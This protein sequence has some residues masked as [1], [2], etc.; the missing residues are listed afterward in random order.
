[1]GS[2]RVSGMRIFVDGEPAE[3][4]ELF[5]TNSN[6][7]ARAFGAVMRIG[8][9]KHAGNW[10]GEVEDLRFY[11]TRTL[12]EAEARVLAVSESVEKIAGVAAEERTDEQQEKLRLHFLENAAPKPIQQ[13]LGQIRKAEAKRLAFADGLP[14][15]MVMQEM[16]PPRSTM[17]RKR[18]E[19]H[20]HGE[21]VEPGVPA[22]FPE[23]PDGAARNRLGFARWLVSGEHP[24][25]AR[26]A[27]NRYWQLLFGQGLVKT[28][29]DFG[30]QGDLPTH[31]EL[32]DFLAI[33]FVES[34]WDVR[35][36]LKTIVLSKTYRQSSRMTPELIVAAP[37]NRLYARA[38]RLRM[39][40]NTLRDQAL[41]VSGLLV[42]KPG[43]AS[44][45]PYQPAKLW[46]EASNVSYA[47]GKG[48]DLY[49]RS[50]YTYWKRT[51]APPSMAVLDTADR[52]W[53][54]VKPRQTNTPLQALTLLN[55]TGF[56]ESA[57]KFGERILAEGGDS[58]VERIEFGFRAVLARRPTELEQQLLAE[59]YAGYRADFTADPQSAKQTL[60]TGS[61]KPAAGDPVE[62]AAAAALANVLLNL[63]E[64]TTRE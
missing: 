15:T 6:R 41:F 35:H 48:D 4:R 58:D 61:S 20:A 8:E 50:V 30:A 44:V 23:M 57:R 36:I 21:E 26:V 46:K 1:D 12:G 24:L 54:S 14:T 31:P 7:A 39:A 64:A 43:G 11:T 45:K 33:E 42:E 51:L 18:G 19:Y 52:E 53:C 16:D 59:A 37:G 25:T 40:G 56:F 17:I 28:S 60:T 27:V 49:R 5:N 2:Q 34:G 62:L 38:P 29:E 32:L 10:K 22:V 13:L 9:S 55:E 3:S 47:V 63:E